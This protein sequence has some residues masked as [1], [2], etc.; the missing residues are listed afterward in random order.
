MNRVARLLFLGLVFSLFWGG[1]Q[2]LLFA[3]SPL[4][5]AGNWQYADQ[6][7]D[8]DTP[9]SFNEY[10]NLDFSKD[11]TDAM[12]FAGTARYNNNRREGGER[13]SLL[14]PTV[15]LDVRNDL[16]S[17]NLSAVETWQESSS[18]SDRVNQSW[19]ANLFTQSQKWPR[20]RLNYGQTRAYD[21]Q[22]P[23]EL[24]QESSYVGVR[25]DYDWS[26]LR[27]LYDYRLNSSEDMT[28]ATTADTSRHFGQIQR[29]RSLFDG[30]LTLS[31]AYQVSYD[32]SDRE[33]RVGIGG[34]VF[35]PINR[36]TLE[37]YSG[38]DDTP[39]LGTLPLNDQ[40]IDGNVIDPAGVEI[41]QS[42]LTQ[43]VALQ[44]SFQPFN[45]LRIYLDREITLT[46][47]ALLAWSFYTSDNGLD[48]VPLGLGTVLE[49]DLEN[50]RSV[51]IVDIPSGNIEVRYFK[52]VS[53]RMA[54]TAETANITELEVG[55]AR[56]S[57]APVEQFD[58]RFIDRK[59]NF[60]M[61]YQPSGQWRFNYNLRHSDRELDPG[62]DSTEL[63]QSLTANYVLNR[64]FSTLV[65]VNQTDRRNEAENKR[66]GRSYSVSM[67]SSPL[68]SLDASAGYTHTDNYL[69]S[70]KENLQDSLNG[71][72]S[73]VIFPDLTTRISVN[74]DRNRNELTSTGTTTTIWRFD[75][76][77]RLS[78]RL[79]A[80]FTYNRT[81][82]QYDGDLSSRSENRD[83]S[84]LGGKLNY[85]PSDILL[86]LSQVDYEENSGDITAVGSA[87]W[88]ATP[89]IQTTGNVVLGWEDRQYKAYDL[90]VLWSLS[91]SI[92][93]RAL[94][95]YL[96]DEGSNSWNTVAS[97]NLTF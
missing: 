29:S 6:G 5:L 41:L 14:T 40:L 68:D 65:G 18:R 70:V 77:A 59:A 91:S 52:A 23:R 43:N 12:N 55:E 69:G 46:A 26:G 76:T 34:E 42:G 20:M 36:L 19:D 83:T 53:E 15:S 10:Y 44:M 11:L 63:N 37:A 74:W 82:T 21:E 78:P 81:S 1:G 71:Y 45:R 60:S 13:H 38:A 49:Y 39:V 51:V 25:F 80:D 17:L 28:T 79:T 84:V 2:P 85:R 8:L 66:V 47:Q 50:G 16:F 56:V 95:G 33:T 73:A 35:I 94:Y 27:F 22:Q 88:R 48:W 7:G 4:G 62:R 86:L 9:W 54:V 75:S 64:Y 67:T 72:I 31:G 61:A 87:T 24:D 58:N 30:R 96:I 3:A 90:Q 97:L 92:S 57:T 32:K 89:K 93:L